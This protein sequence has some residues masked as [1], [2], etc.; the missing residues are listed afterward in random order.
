ME[1]LRD[2]CKK[3]PISNFLA[4]SQ[5]AWQEECPVKCSEFVSGR[6]LGAGGSW[7]G[8]NKKLQESSPSSKE[9]TSLAK[10]DTVSTSSVT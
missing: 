2:L 3:P 10:V 9:G 5:V 6:G 4:I 7:H 8:F 1:Q